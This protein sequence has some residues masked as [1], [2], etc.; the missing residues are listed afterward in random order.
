MQYAK[1]ATVDNR[2]NKQLPWPEPRHS[3]S[4]KRDTDH[5][6]VKLECKQQS[7]AGRAAA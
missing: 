6:N 7:T 4:Y 3:F 5:D 1:V 2:I